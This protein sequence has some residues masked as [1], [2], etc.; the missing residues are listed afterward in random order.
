MEDLPH[1]YTASVNARPDNP[2]AIAG[3]GLPTLQ[4]APPA[5]FGGPGNEWSPEE[6]LMASV[7]SCM[8][9]SFRAIAKMNKLE[10]S[11]L[12]VDASGELDKVE[13]AMKFTG[14]KL[15]ARLTVASEADVAKAERLLH[16]AEETCFVSNSLNCSSEL[17]CEVTVA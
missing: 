8:V 9:L 15:A 2:V 14:V 5:Q 10:W 7:S 16:K 6:L 13:R 12:Q 17:S 11:D 4:A 3:E 1:T